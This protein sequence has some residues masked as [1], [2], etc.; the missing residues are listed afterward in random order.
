MKNIIILALLAFH[1][2][3]SFGQVYKELTE[4]L[5]KTLDNK[6]VYIQQKLVF[7]QHKKDTLHIYKASNDLRKQILV[8]LELVYEYQSFVYDSAQYYVKAAKAVA[9]QIKDNSMISLIKIREG[10]VLLSSGLFKEAFDTLNSVKPVLLN[11]SLKSIF[12]STLAR[13]YYDIADYVHDSIFKPEY[14]SRGNT[15]IDSALR[16][17]MPNTNEYWA[18]KSL[19]QIKKSDWSR[20][21]YVF[22]YWIK[23]FHLPTHQYAIATSSLGYIFQMTGSPNQAIEYF[24]KAAIADVKTAT[25]ETVALR[26]LATLFYEKGE[27]R[28][29]YRYIIEALNQALYYNARHR[30]LEIG[31]ILPII[32][33]ERMNVI[34]HQR[35]RIIIFSVFISVLLVALIVALRRL[36]IA[37]LIIRKSNEN[38]FEANKI[39]DEYIANFF[40]QNSD[41]IEKIEN[42]QKWVNRMVA[43]KQF[44][45]LKKFPQYI[46]IQHERQ[47][48]Y[49]RFDKIFLKLFPNFVEEFNNLLNDGEQIQVKD[50]ELLN[51][52][53]RIYALIRLGINDNEKIASF[54]NYSVNTIY[55]YKT[56]IKSK[57][58]SSVDQF[59][60][61]VME[62]KSI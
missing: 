25:M 20:A 45:T 32:E 46:N 38:L 40:N 33:R 54:L 30:Q 56:K 22:E 60:Q 17:A 55:T 16:Y 10:F 48:L 39:K 15:Y 58:R 52:D 41:Y 18:I 24:A 12:Y 50:D 53:L 43:A 19:Q 21:K 59:K 29:A 57:A 35:D 8:S 62:I 36:N 61:K 11:D 5:E 28:L 1:F 51:T 31:Q 3:C 13:A 42:L 23:N 37:R 7:I 27:E 47:L 2:S 9:C 34:K 6:D 26:N 4:E 49:E 14:I 44:D